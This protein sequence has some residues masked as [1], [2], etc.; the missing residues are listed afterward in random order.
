MSQTHR[1]R[2][3]YSSSSSSATN[4]SDT[5]FDHIDNAD[6]IDHTST[7]LL[8]VA[9]YSGVYTNEDV[10]H[11]SKVISVVLSDYSH[12]RLL[13]SY[14]YCGA[15]VLVGAYESTKMGAG[16]EHPRTVLVF[17]VHRPRIKNRTSDG[18]RYS[19]K[20]KNVLTIYGRLHKTGLTANTCNRLIRVT[21]P[22]N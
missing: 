1:Y 9:W 17:Y 6:T 10:F 22:N 11:T 8:C 2:S 21:P 20:R 18:R 3:C 12:S 14:F 7:A 16:Q 5:A 13:L 4:S 19:Q 15:V